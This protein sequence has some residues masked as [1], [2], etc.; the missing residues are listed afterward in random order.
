LINKNEWLRE[1]IPVDNLGRPHSLY[2]SSRITLSVDEQIFFRHDREREQILNELQLIE[3]QK[4]KIWKLYMGDLKE[5][6]RI[7]KILNLGMPKTGTTSFHY[8]MQKL[9]LISIHDPRIAEHTVDEI[10]KEFMYANSF[11]GMLTPRYKDI[12]TAYPNAKYIFT[13]R[14]VDS[15]LPSFRRQTD[16]VGGVSSTD[17]QKFRESLFGTAKIWELDDEKVIH[18]Y[19]TFNEEIKHFFSD[20]ENFMELNFIESDNKKKLMLDLLKFLDIKGNSE[21]E[22]PREN[23]Y[24]KLN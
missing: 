16:E 23:V 4:N 15:W 13:I 2:T 5:I 6:N 3:E 9:D 7:N 17:V 22:F 18:V 14:N 21:I 20:K 12:Y 24:K 19:N 1:K 8:L 11:S 10:Q